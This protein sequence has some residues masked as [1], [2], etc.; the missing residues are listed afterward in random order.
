MLIEFRVENHRSIA[1]EQT[2][3]FVT[4][5][6]ADQEDRRS[7]AAP[8]CADRLVPV[9]AIFGAN[10]SGKTNVL[11]ALVWMRFAIVSSQAHWLP[12]QG[13]PRQPFGW[14]GWLGRP[15]KFEA[16]FALEGTR[17]RY[18]F[19]VDNTVVVREQVDAW[20]SGRK[21]TWLSREGDKFRFGKHLLGENRVV[22]DVT[23]PNALFLSAAAQLRHTQL[24]PIW[25]WFADAHPSSW[26]VRRRWH[27]GATAQ[28]VAGMLETQP[29]LF[30]LSQGAIDPRAALLEI[31]RQA[32]MDIADVRVEAEETRTGPKRHNVFVRHESA[33]DA[34]LPIEEESA[35]TQA[36]V[37][38][39]PGLFESI[40]QGR[41]MVLDELDASL[42]PKLTRAIVHAFQSPLAN[43]HGAQLACT[44][45]DTS[46]MGTLI[47][48]P[49][50]RRDEIWFTEKQASGATTLTPCAAYHVRKN[51]NLERGYVQG[52]YGASPLIGPLIVGSE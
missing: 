25:R 47:G 43:P 44:T 46:L 40:G 21:Q 39:L 2:L 48:D 11:D 28:W 30:P 45:H 18:A 41:L 34:W 42:H 50:L 22:Q 14:G 52:R 49:T 4:G 10:A 33:G 35:G 19:E 24:T 15:S 31:L 37:Q 7:R 23:R 8:G 5:R 20:P 51:E 1:D 17:Y 36:F 13:V 27:A 16:T 6:P 32:D 26:L 38:L 12:G 3:S 9:V 29:K